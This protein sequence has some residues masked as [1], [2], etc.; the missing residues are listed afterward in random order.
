MKWRGFFL[1][2]ALHA[3]SIALAFSL[4]PAQSSVV[5]P[6]HLGAVETTRPADELAPANALK[7]QLPV[8]QAPDLPSHEALELPLARS[9]PEPPPRE[10]TL[11]DPAPA[12]PLPQSSEPR[13]ATPRF[14]LPRTRFAPA[15]SPAPSPAKRA[16]APVEPAPKGESDFAPPALLAW[17]VPDSLARRFRGKF[18]AII[19]VGANGKA[20]SVTLETGTGD[21]AIDREVRKALLNGRYSPAR[22]GE[23]DVESTLRQ[24]FEVG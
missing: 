22:K 6:V 2:A 10:E 8:L 9:A 1:A 4:M 21:N 19:V 7:P 12:L 20:R 17:D 16:A 23:S 24:P 15:S 13:R 18:V 14:E 11:P 3:T 5:E